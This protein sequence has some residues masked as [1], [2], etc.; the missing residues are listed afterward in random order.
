M[1]TVRHTVVWACYAISCL[2]SD[3]DV[4]KCSKKDNISKR[5]PSRISFYKNQNFSC[6][7]LPSSANHAICCRP[8]STM[9]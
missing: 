7:N 2:L 9:P 5:A 1:P 8:M 6:Q 3:S 4:E